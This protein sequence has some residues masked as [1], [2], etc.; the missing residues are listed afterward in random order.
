MRQ[1]NL[2]HAHHP[3]KPVKKAAAAL[4]VGVGHFSDPWELQV[5][6]PQPRCPCP[7][8]GEGAALTSVQPPA[9]GMCRTSKSAGCDASASP[10]KRAPWRGTSVAHVSPRPRPPC[11]VRHPPPPGRAWAT[12]WS[13]CYSWAAKST[14]M[15]TSTTPT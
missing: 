15:K 9:T 11:L 14:Q 4:S 6:R 13:T 8:V 3:G 10:T 1:Q 12:T 7:G 2:H 5:R